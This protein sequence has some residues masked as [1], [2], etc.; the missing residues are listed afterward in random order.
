MALA[1]G[2]GA[3]AAPSQD[4]LEVR[5]PG[6][7]RE[8]FLDVVP[9]DARSVPALRID[10]GWTVANDWSTPTTL[11]RDGQAVEVRL[12]EQADSITAAVRVPWGVV[13][14]SPPDAFLRRLATA[15]EL[16]ATVHWGGWTDGPIDAWHRLFSYNDFARPSLPS[17]AVHLGLHRP[18]GTEPVRIDAATFAFGDVVLRNQLLLWEG[19]EPL[20]PGGPARGGVSLRLDL[21]IPTGLLARM[22]GSGGWDVG[23]GVLGTWQATSWLTGHAIV[24]GSAWSGMPGGLPLQPRTWQ[25]SA[26]LA[27]VVMLGEVSLH[28]EDRWASAPFQYGWTFVEVNPEWNLQSSASNAVTLSQ[29][30][31]AGGVRWGPLT[32]WFAEDFTIGSVPGLGPRWFYDSNAPDVAFGLTLTLRP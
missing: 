3:R 20:D 6:T 18:L 32:F 23:L 24:S 13:L 11:T 29:N 4:P 8:L 5:I 14:G 25:A 9:W 16:R 28:L 1:A 19:G 30:Q 7:L 26:G 22:G 15:V 10:A 17:N 27:L 31:I 12:D 2:A 21:K